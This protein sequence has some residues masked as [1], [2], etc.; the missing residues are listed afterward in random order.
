M[1]LVGAIC[2]LLG[3]VGLGFL[4]VQKEKERI[5]F[6]QLWENIM[7]MFLSEISYRKQSLALAS[8]EIGGKIGGKEGECFRKICERMQQYA[9]DRFADI[10]LLEWSMYFKERKLSNTEKKLIEEFVLITGFEDEIIQKKIVEEQLRKW[11]ETRI[12]IQKGQ[13]ERERIV[14]TVSLCGGIVLVL[15]L[16]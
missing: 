1:K 8:Y 15:I 4:Y 9:G 3:A 6:A 2:I 5:A 14:W 10:W 13:Q 7:E 16:I 11:K 12:N